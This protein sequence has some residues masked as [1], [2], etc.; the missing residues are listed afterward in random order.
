MKILSPTGR[1]AA[2]VDV[3]IPLLA[4]MLFASAAIARRQRRAGRRA[5]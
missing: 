1:A 5:G 2:G 3:T 4:L